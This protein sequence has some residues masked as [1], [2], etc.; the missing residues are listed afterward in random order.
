VSRMRFTAIVAVFQRGFISML[1]RM[2][3]PET[4]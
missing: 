1:N 3:V 4:G 2:G